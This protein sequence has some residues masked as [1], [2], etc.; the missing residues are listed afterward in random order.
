[1]ANPTHEIGR[2]VTLRNPQMPNRKNV[3][4]HFVRYN[5]AED[6]NSLLGR[7]LTTK[8]NTVLTVSQKRAKIYADAATYL[9]TS[10]AVSMARLPQGLEAI[11]DTLRE[12]GDKVTTTFLMEELLPQWSNIASNNLNRGGV[13][14]NTDCLP[15]NFK[16]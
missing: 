15:S 12:K 13:L 5:L 2:F 14:G 8:N 7:L 6:E 16:V 3:E 11:T 9:T 4:N 10:E 1:M